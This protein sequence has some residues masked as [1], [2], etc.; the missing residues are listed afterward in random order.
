V[1]KLRELVAAKGVAPRVGQSVRPN[2]GSKPEIGESKD[3]RRV[4]DLP[5]RPR[6]EP[7]SAHEVALIELAR[8]R[9]GRD[10]GACQCDRIR[11]PRKAGERSCI[12]NLLPGQAW[13]LHEIA[14]HAGLLGGL[15]VGS[16]KTI[17]GILTPLAMPECELA[18]L[19][20]PP[21]LVEQLIKEYELLS[22]HWRVP[23]MVVHGREYARAVPGEPVLHVLPYSRLS[24][25]SCATFLDD[26]GPDTV[27]C[28]ECDLL[29]DPG[30]TRSRRFLRFLGANPQTRG[31]AWS[32]SMTDDSITD[33]AHLAAICLGEGSPV[34][35]EP[36]VVSE[37]ATAIDPCDD[38][39]PPGALLQLCE[40]GEHA[41]DGFSRRLLETPGVVTS[42][43]SSVD[44]DLVIAERAAPPLPPVI[45]EYLNELRA[46]WL[47]PDGEELVEPLSV[48]RCARELALGLYYRWIF[49]RGEPRAVI[50]EWFA[51]RK[52]WRRELREKLKESKE[53]L[54]SPHLCALAAA[55][56]W[57]QEVDKP[58]EPP[59]PQEVAD[60]AEQL[61]LDVASGEMSEE[62][63][64]KALEAFSS[65]PTTPR[66]TWKAETW[67]RWA[68]VMK[69]V[70]PETEA[71]LVDPFLAEDAAA[72]ARESLGIVWYG[73]AAF[74]GWVSQIAKLP[75]HGG[76]PGAE[77]RILAEKGNRSIVVSIDSHGRGRDG[78]Q[79]L[80]DRQLVSSPPTSSK[81]WQQLLGRL[82]RQGQQ[83]PTVF[84]DYYRHTPEF[85]RAMTVALRR[86]DYVEGTFREPQKL[87]FGL[88]AGGFDFDDL[89]AE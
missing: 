30:S 27:I 2:W 78:L 72:W 54:D 59:T 15:Q 46:T 11:P 87:M 52:G 33:Y 65:P 89:Q 88:D 77:K 4:R 60:Y 69:E 42:T 80:F 75:M 38:P 5:R 84:T 79:R 53:H 48:V 61:R 28:D 66:P 8:E 3:L 23:S 58:W 9:F 51:A 1:I 25:K 44:I 47:R 35:L 56:A 36:A 63:A 45:R 32:G 14:K 39:A 31:C 49:P 81:K 34:P 85:K 40:P 22:Q 16:G 18:L 43:S 67:P 62:Q 74:G 20:C 50:D 76:G 83:S 6:P 55:R 68:R 29:S 21:T 37:W 70:R 13:G 10:N 24:I 82:H 26:L 7:G 86:A 41:R 17:L 73:T 12:L 19:L 71:V 57:G 64:E